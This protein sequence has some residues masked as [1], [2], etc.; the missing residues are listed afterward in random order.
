M[1]RSE[2]KQSE[3]Q[4]YFFLFLRFFHF[5]RFFFAFFRFKFF[6]SLRFSH[7]CFEA[8]QSKAKFKSIFFSLFFA[9]VAFLSLFSLHFRFALI[10]L[11]NF[12]L[13][14]P[15]F[16]LQIFGVSHRSESCEIRL[17]FA[18]QRNEIFA[19]ISNFASEAK[20]RAHPTVEEVHIDARA[21]LTMNLIWFGY[22]DRLF[23]WG[24]G[25]IFYSFN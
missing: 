9:F 7:F 24:G 1:L 3:I 25:G 10:F 11:L 16:S 22:I 15:S 17:F 2:T 4:V 12:L 19:S 6:A 20:V 21:L 13:I 5:F 14:L 23:Q 18:S 8:K